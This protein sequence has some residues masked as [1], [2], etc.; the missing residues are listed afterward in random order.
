MPSYRY[1]GKNGQVW[2]FESERELTDAELAGLKPPDEEDEKPKAPATFESQALSALKAANPLDPFGG[3]APTIAGAITPDIV[4]RGAKAAV[5]GVSDLLQIPREWTTDKF[6]RQ[7]S[8][9]AGLA[10]PDVPGPDGRPHSPTAPELLMEGVMPPREPGGRA[11]SRDYAVGMLDAIPGVD[12]ETAQKYGPFAEAL[13]P[14]SLQLAGSL[15]NL[16]AAVARRNGKG[17]KAAEVVE[18]LARVPAGIAAGAATDPMTALGSVA[19]GRA[20]GA[21]TPLALARLGKADQALA[22]TGA[23][24]GGA[25]SLPEGQ[26]AQEALE[27]GDLAGAAT[28]G[29]SAALM[30]GMAG[31]GVKGASEI[32]AAT[33]ELKGPAGRP[34]IDDPLL[35]ADQR[36]A[37]KAELDAEAAPRLEAERLEAV[38][39]EA[40]QK[41]DETL[42]NVQAGRLSARVGEEATAAAA[43]ADEAAK[44]ARAAI[45]KAAQEKGDVTRTAEEAKAAEVGDLPA[46][47]AIDR[48]LERGGTQA[49]KATQT[50]LENIPVH[51]PEV[52]GRLRA[53]QFQE[54]QL[55]G[56]FWGGVRGVLEDVIPGN[57]RA[58]AILFQ[59]E[60]APV[61]DGAVKFEAISTKGQR[62]VL[63]IRQKLDGMWTAL[64]DA[65]RSQGLEPPKKETNYLPRIKKGQS[66]PE[67]EQAAR[68][69]AQKERA[70]I[71]DAA[72]AIQVSERAKMSPEA[73]LA[74]LRQGEHVS[75]TSGVVVSRA[76]RVRRFEKERVPNQPLKDFRTDLGVLQEYGQVMARRIAELKHLGR[77]GE[78]VQALID[79][80]SDAPAKVL[81]LTVGDKAFAQAIV[82]RTRGVKPVTAGQQAA[83]LARTLLGAQGLVFSSLQ[84]PLTLAQ[85]SA[86]SMRHPVAAARG[87]QG[88]LFDGIKRGDL[89]HPIRMA[90]Q[91]RQSYRRAGI[92]AEEVGAVT[93]NTAEEIAAAFGLDASARQETVAGKI[94]GKAQGLPHIRALAAT[95]RAMRIVGAKVG[96]FVVPKMVEAAK[97]GS[98]SE[99]R[100]LAYMGIDWKN[101]K[102]TPEELATAMKFFADE[103]NFRPNI[104]R[105]PP[106]AS[107]PIGRFGFQ[108]AS[109]MHQMTKFQ[110]FLLKNPE[111]LAAFAAVGLPLAHLS[112]QARF[113]LKGTP[114][115]ERTIPDE[116]FGKAL[117]ETMKGQRRVDWTKGKNE[118][119][120]AAIHALASLGVGAIYQSMLERS[121]EG[122]ITDLVPIARVMDRTF[123]AVAGSTAEA[124][125]LRTA[126]AAA[127]AEGNEAEAGRLRAALQKAEGV[128]ETQVAK[129]GAALVPGP[130]VSEAVRETTGELKPPVPGWFGRLRDVAEERGIVTPTDPTQA[131]SAGREA[132]RRLGEMQAERS[133]AR[134]QGEAMLTPQPS[135]TLGEK[136]E[137]TE[138]SAMREKYRLA[139]IQAIQDEDY[140]EVWRLRREARKLKI[141]FGRKSLRSLEGRVIRPTEDDYEQDQEEEAMTQ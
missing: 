6:A 16:D 7:G 92:K 49:L 70:S 20:L 73:V 32:G 82:D 31:L 52:A 30:A 128:N 81:G 3:L 103:T 84:Q 115:D 64:E 89:V 74:E 122:K 62:A 83:G 80:M 60:V 135:K 117:S 43:T 59:N 40:R 129:A 9:F 34:Y 61:L 63:G 45:E 93:A 110:N 5:A 42:A 17:A 137:T 2:R 46:R 41:A 119:Q 47:Q 75:G 118:A 125:Q 21:K 28:H 97:K 19:A 77:N 26:E 48:V 104:L 123:S 25:G 58:Q 76:D 91:I 18:D 68:E 108:Y 37:I 98:G 113:T 132:V 109:F 11:T 136:L 33:R 140:A 106:A 44:A 107:S 78:A 116:E 12:F 121:G 133:R 51:G 85:I 114:Y 66:L 57:D 102:G 56:A 112:N 36:A 29:L 4:K 35:T 8:R 124:V 87:V 130:W 22:A 111:R 67:I 13:L 10:V 39:A 139:I 65:Y 105:L 1:T 50:H 141:K 23:V 90:K 127:E 72:Y 86:M 120:I 131:G 14:P 99:Q 38:A 15:G 134:G 126:I 94:A 101:Y 95:D 79:R 24:I 71:E 27:R 100:A 138:K 88:L 69:L 55:G 54:E 96:E 53:A